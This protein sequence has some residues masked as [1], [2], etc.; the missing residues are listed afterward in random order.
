MAIQD[1]YRLHFEARGKMYSGFRVA[2]P[3]SLPVY[4]AIPNCDGVVS[5]GVDQLAKDVVTLSS[6]QGDGVFNFG[7]KRGMYQRTLEYDVYL[8]FYPVLGTPHWNRLILG[9]SVV[10]VF[11]V[12]YNTQLSLVVRFEHSNDGREFTDYVFGDRVNR[13]FLFDSRTLYD[14]Q[15]VVPCFVDFGVVELTQI[16]GSMDRGI[17]LSREPLTWG[18]ISELNF[19]QATNTLLLD[20]YF[21]SSDDNLEDLFAELNCVLNTS[22]FNAD[23][24][25]DV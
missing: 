23:K 24:V 3:L 2:T 10:R 16:I 17:I 4:V 13:Q 25:R 14:G 8:N 11:P 21:S 5:V 12:R 15:A 20:G 6:P 22:D 9:G 18:V 7:D 1:D 19:A